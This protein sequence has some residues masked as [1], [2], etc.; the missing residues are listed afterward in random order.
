V[1][2]RVDVIRPLTLDD[3]EAMTALLA[4]N[5][6]FLRPTEPTRPPDFYTLAAQIE[7]LGVLEHRRATDA[8]YAYA[9]LDEGE[10]A[11]TIS[12]VHVVR[13]SL[14]S[15]TVGYFVD[16]ERNGRGLASRALAAIVDE[17]FG[18]LGLHRVEA[19]TLVD[20]VASQRVLEKNRF[21]RIG[22]ATRYLLIGAEWLDHVLF[23]RT[24]ED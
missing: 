18:P 1:S 8:G 17:A 16:A 4:R 22:V 5:R 15:A 12:L 23:Q 14:Q 19:G 20:N 7:R 9:I 3:A 6:E 10:L 24:A 13:G 11:G 21:T 2:A